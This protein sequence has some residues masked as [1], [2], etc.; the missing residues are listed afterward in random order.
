MKKLFIATLLTLATNIYCQQFDPLHRDFGINIG[1]LG[2]FD[3]NLA[4]GTNI[5]V[6]GLTNI[7]IGTNNSYSAASN[8]VMIGNNYAVGLLA[9]NAMIKIGN[10]NG[11]VRSGGI[12]IGDGAGAGTQAVGIGYQSDAFG[13]QSITLGGSSQANGTGSIIIGAGVADDGFADSIALGGFS[14]TFTA[15]HWMLLGNLTTTNT[16]IRGRVVANLAG[17]T[18]LPTTGIAGWPANSSGYLLNNGSGTLSWGTPSGAGGIATNLGT[19]FGNTFTNPVLRGDISMDATN[20][21]Y[22]WF[23]RNVGNDLLLSNTVNGASFLFKSNSIIS[24]TTLAGALDAAQLTGTIPG[25]VVANSPAIVT[26]TD[27]GTLTTGLPLVGNGA[28]GVMPTN[29]LAGLNQVTT[30]SL[31]INTNGFDPGYLLDCNKSMIGVATNNTLPIG[32]MTNWSSTKLN[33]ILVVVTNTA[34]SGTPIQI[35]VPAWAKYTPAGATPPYCTNVLTLLFWSTH[36][37]GTNY[38]SISN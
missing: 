31:L 10:G 23:W 2:R 32:V 1:P 4:G 3:G 25:G 15:P 19:G 21:T 37:T 14:E 17:G 28:K 12:A 30:S 16:H 20:G 8:S 18:N 24:T 7:V 36:G 13:S 6:I 35:S 38:S 11:D 33:S 26:N 9:G 29:N 5:G 34:G 22:G 27:N